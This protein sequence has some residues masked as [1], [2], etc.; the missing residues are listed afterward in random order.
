VE[1]SALQAPVRIGR[2]SLAGP[3]LRLRSD[4][5]LVAL[6]RAGSDEAFGVIHDRYRQRLFAYARQMLSGS[7]SDAEDA[8]QDVFI[9]AYSSLRGGDK[10][11]TL[12]PWL[13]RVAHNR[14]ID[15]LRRPAQQT[16]ELWDGAGTP[17][18]DPMVQ[19]ERREDLRRLVEDVRR[20]PEHQRSVLLMRELEGLSYD[21][22]AAAHAT[23]VAAIKSLLVRARMGLVQSA[24]ARDAACSEIRHDL[25]LAHGRGVRANGQARRHLRDCAG[26]REYRTELKRMERSFAAL[27]PVG[28]LAAIAN[29]LGLGG[30]GAGS[31]AGGA[32]AGAASGGAAA[33]GGTSL[34]GAAVAATATKV[35]AVVV[36]SVVVTG[37]AAVTVEH[38]FAKSHHSSAK[39]AAVHRA[40]PAPAASAPVAADLP[41][42][43]A[44]ATDAATPADTTATPRPP[45]APAAPQTAPVTADPAP[46]GSSDIAG[47][48]KLQTGGTVAPDT[49][50]DD[51]AASDGPG[52]ASVADDV[53]ISAGSDAGAPTGDA[54]PRDASTPPAAAPRTAPTGATS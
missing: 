17:V 30:A 34:G 21:D 29:L 14:C 1:A 51:P 49:S 48:T 47:D 24:E 41:K 27:Y 40:A 35:A 26:C 50:G 31:G 36:A 16:V 28:P 9:R 18:E 32:A 19:A 37:G 11:I 23:S 20:L 4:D 39:P 12:R 13:Y 2:L 54:A 52:A 33:V 46:A 10:P 42:I 45:A 5:Q 3:L 25:A 38:Q 44:P 22:L 8:M 7:Q 43:T 15:Q 53:T 6:F